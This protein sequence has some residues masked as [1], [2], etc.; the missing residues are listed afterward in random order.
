M[1]GRVGGHGRRGRRRPGTGRR[2]RAHRRLV[3]L[4]VGAATGLAACGNATAP[5]SHAGNTDGVFPDRIVVGGLASQTGPLP[6]NFAPVLTGA[7]AYFDMVNADGGVHG[8]R[9]D[10]ARQLDD[11]SSPSVDASQAR[12][13]VDQYKVFAVVGV[14][15]PSFSGAAYL[16]SHGVPTFGLN[17]NPNSQWLAGPSMYGNTG[18]YTDFTSPQPAAAFLAEQHHVRAAAVLAYN[19]AASRQ[20]CQGVLNAFR[21]YRVHVAFEDLSIPAPATDLHSDVTRM[22]A[23]HVDMVTS[24]MDLSGNVL[25]SQTMRQAGMTSALQYWFDG[26]DQAALRQ[27]PG[28]MAGVYLLVNHAPYEVAKLHPGAYPGMDKFLAMLRR[29]APGTAPS[30]A[31][32]AGWT[33]ADLFVTGLRAI[34][35]DVTRIRLVRALNSIDAFTADGIAPPVDWRIG[36]EAKGQPNS[37]VAFVQVQRDRFVAVYG[38]PP[39]VF[40]CFPVPNPAGPPV[41]PLARLPAGVPPLGGRSG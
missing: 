39:S 28:A 9:I 21:R 11:Q 27:F 25:L 30:E 31:A 6:A 17:V 37:C 7:K 5:T 13:L 29:Y 2:P 34:G 36:H 38:T 4:A 3:A 33:S 8:R 15:T 14:A 40:T 22:K 18:S 32:L 10:Y 26:Y 1:G 16:A 41:V 20:G 19:I 12:A 23:A 35:R 24:C